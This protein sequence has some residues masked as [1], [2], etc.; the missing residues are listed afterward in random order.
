[1]ATHSK[2]NNKIAITTMHGKLFFT[3]SSIGNKSCVP[4][5]RRIACIAVKASKAVSLA[6]ATVPFA[7]VEL[8]DQCITSNAILIIVRVTYFVIH[9]DKVL[10]EN[11]DN[12]IK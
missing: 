8:F 7:I 4:G 2:G 12:D 5:F 1:M 9:S 3:R 6:L 10:P 11:G